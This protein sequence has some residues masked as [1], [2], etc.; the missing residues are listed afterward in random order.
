MELYYKVSKYSKTGKAFLA[1]IDRVKKFRKKA[2]I[3]CEKYGIREMYHIGWSR[4][5]I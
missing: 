4:I 3:V 1:I 2:T 5:G